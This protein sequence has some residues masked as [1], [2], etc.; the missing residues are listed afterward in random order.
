MPALGWRPTSTRKRWTWLLFVP[1]G[2]GVITQLGSIPARA[3]VFAVRTGL[4]GAVG[5]M[6]AHSAAGAYA[7]VALGLQVV[8]AALWMP[9]V[10]PFPTFF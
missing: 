7:A 8:L 1:V 4:L 5:A 9:L 2:V 3:A 10:M 6:E